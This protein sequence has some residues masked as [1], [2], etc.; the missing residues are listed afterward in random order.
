MRVGEGMASS[1]KLGKKGRVRN[2]EGGCGD[3]GLVFRGENP[4]AEICQGKES[5]ARVART[6]ILVYIYIYIS[7]TG[8]PSPGSGPGNQ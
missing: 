3:M 4:R 6:Q 8:V 5:S 2:A 1:F 7:I